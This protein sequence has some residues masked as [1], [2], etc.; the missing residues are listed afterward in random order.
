MLL[1][2]SGGI[3]EE[4]TYLQIPCVT[5]RENTE[6]PSTVDI[7]TN[8]IVGTDPEKITEAAVAAIDCKVKKGTVPDFWDGKTA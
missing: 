3:Q 5:M 7:G 4:T 1:T 8:I 6:R 2:D